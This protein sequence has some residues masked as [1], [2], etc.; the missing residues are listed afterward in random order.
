MQEVGLDHGECVAYRSGF[1]I[2]LAS[3]A[4]NL[5]LKGHGGALPAGG[6]PFE[7]YFEADDVAA[8]RDRVLGSGAALV[9][10]IEE[11]PWGQRVFRAYD[12]DGHVIELAEPMEAV[13]K[14]YLALGLSAE[15]AARR[16]SMPVEF[17]R[18][19]SGLARK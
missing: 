19:V 7:L 10:D 14:R 13:V 15:E 3:H 9:H 1:S 12:P 17:V 16:S 11:Q 5:V 6:G 2:W 18:Q 8:A 4:R